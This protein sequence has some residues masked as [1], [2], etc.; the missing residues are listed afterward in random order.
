MLQKMANRFITHLC[1]SREETYIP[2]LT[3][4]VSKEVTEQLLIKANIKTNL[5]CELILRNL[6]DKRTKSHWHTLVTSSRR[7]SSKTV[8]N[9]LSWLKFNDLIKTKGCNT[10]KAPVGLTVHESYRT[11]GN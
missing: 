1:S 8:C 7:H 2:Q 11:K 3:L 6:L 5:T 10:P 4:L 9:G